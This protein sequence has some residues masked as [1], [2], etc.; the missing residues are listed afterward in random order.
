MAIS[1]KEVLSSV[2]SSSRDR[3]VHLMGVECLVHILGRVSSGQLNPWFVPSKSW[4]CSSPVFQSFF[5]TIWFNLE[6]SAPGVYHLLWSPDPDEGSPT[7]CLWWS[8]TGGE[9]TYM[10]HISRSGCEP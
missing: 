5:G 8:P 4:A 6:S 9:A 10:C 3:Q 7:G 2:Q 1:G